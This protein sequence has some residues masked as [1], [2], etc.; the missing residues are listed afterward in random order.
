[1]IEARSQELPPYERLT[2]FA[3]SLQPL[4]RTQVGKLRRHLLPEAF[5]QAKAGRGPAHA[6]KEMTEQ[7]RALLDE[8]PAA[9]VWAWLQDRFKGT[10]LTLDTSPELDLGLDSFAWISLGDGAAGALRVPAH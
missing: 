7:D 5:A 3:V 4:P 1:M 6:A 2:D 9:E 8:S 10:V